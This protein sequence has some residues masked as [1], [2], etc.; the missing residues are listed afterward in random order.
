MS[1]PPLARPNSRRPGGF[2]A[3]GTTAITSTASSRRNVPSE[4][5]LSSR[6]GS[7][8]REGLV[9]SG[10]IW[11]LR[12]VRGRASALLRHWLCAT[13]P[14]EHGQFLAASA[15]F[16]DGLR[17]HRDPR[18]RRSF[19]VAATH[20][21]RVGEPVHEDATRAVATMVL[22]RHQVGHPSPRGCDSNPQVAQLKDPT[23]SLSAT[24]VLANPSRAPPPRSMSTHRERI[25]LCSMS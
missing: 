1:T 10:R 17:A 4:T 3:R 2:A 11:P 14:R 19:P 24:E 22:L 9:G 18:M 23:P 20:H 8:Q 6:T 25:G 21:D 12:V 15:S 7:S 16:R 13:R 5:A